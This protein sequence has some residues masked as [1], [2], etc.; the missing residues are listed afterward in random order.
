MGVDTMA[1][2][3]QLLGSDTIR[4]ER[5]LPGPVERVWSFLTD[6]DKRAGWLA[7]GPIA[8]AA[9]GAV[10]LEFR[11]AALSPEPGDIPDRFRHMEDGA[12]LRGRVTR[13]DPPRLL[14][15]TWGEDA[16]ASEVTFELAPVGPSV[17][18]ILTHRGIT[19]RPT[20]LM[21]SAGWHTHLAILE[22]RLDG[23]TTANFWT[24]FAAAEAEYEAHLP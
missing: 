2:H 12:T 23:R 19:G 16:D 24:L 14:A 18:L 13:C 1:A 9:G 6:P 5:L 22:A 11:H 21:V 10:R 8:L 17:R 4:F 3:G 15:F 20:M 7:G